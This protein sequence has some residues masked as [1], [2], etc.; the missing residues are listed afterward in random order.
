MKKEML[1]HWA[2]V[3]Q[4]THPIDLNRKIKKVLGN[5]LTEMKEIYCRWII[6]SE[7]SYK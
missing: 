3:Q 1:T 6:P 4:L 5:S 2:E 7:Y